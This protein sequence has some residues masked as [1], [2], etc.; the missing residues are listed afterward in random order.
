[1]SAPVCADCFSGHIHSG[2]P[3]G[4]VATIHGLP[5]YIASPEDGQTPKGLVVIISD[6]FGWDLVNNRLLADAYAKKGPFLVYLP[7]FMQGKHCAVQMDI[8]AHTGC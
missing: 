1:M 8:G 6:A 7:D 2:Q 3:A 4:T 5:T